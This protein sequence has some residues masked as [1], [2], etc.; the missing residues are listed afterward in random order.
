MANTRASLLNTKSPSVSDFSLFSV[1]P[2]S[3]LLVLTTTA[4]SL[5]AA[6]TV[7]DS[8]TRDPGVASASFH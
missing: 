5:S 1:A 3:G 6:V 2:F 8:T 4:R 7:I